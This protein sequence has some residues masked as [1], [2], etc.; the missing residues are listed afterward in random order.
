MSYVT[1]FQAELTPLPNS[2]DQHEL[3][4]RGLTIMSGLT[5]DI[6]R[7]LVECSKDPLVARYCKNDAGKRFASVDSIE[8]EWL[9]K[10]RLPLPLVR[11]AGSGGLE[12]VGFGWMGPGIPGDDEPTISGAKTTLAIR[13]YE[14]ARGNGNALPYTRGIVVA[15]QVLHGVGGEWLEA[16]G[17]NVA[18]LRTYEQAGFTEVA[19]IAGER[20]GNTID[21][22]YMTLGDISSQTS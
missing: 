2:V 11:S 14:G 5:H 16:W 4:E 15:H 22:V 17:D 6:A 21:R 19:R 10:N 12:L 1:E 7:Q 20:E 8:K 13:L 18:A 9:S 3:N